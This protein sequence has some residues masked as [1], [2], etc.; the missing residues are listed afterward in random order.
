VGVE[1]EPKTKKHES[2]ISKKYKYD[3]FISSKSE[4]YPIAEKIYDFLISNKYS[5]FLASKEL[6]KLGEAQYSRAIDGALDNTHHMIVVASS[7]NNIQSTWVQYEWSTFHS[8]LKSGYKEGNLLT[9]IDSSIV[10]LSNLPASL[11]H[12]QSFNFNEWQNFILGYLPKSNFNSD[13]FKGDV[14]YKIRV[15]RACWLYLDDEKIQQLEAGKIAKISLSGGEYLRKVVD[16]ENQDVYRED[17]IDISKNCIL[18]DIDLYSLYKKQNRTD[19]WFNLLGKIQN[20]FRKQIFV[21]SFIAF[22][23]CALFLYLI[24]GIYLLV[25]SNRE[26]LW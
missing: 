3:V 2:N 8:D 10:N 20:I 17:K 19:G 9:I 7:L 16:Y 6:E 25:Y 14:Q 15:N 24:I 11:R 21:K 1:R 26:S 23:I 22:I 13:S 12:Q 18:D 4:D 5:V